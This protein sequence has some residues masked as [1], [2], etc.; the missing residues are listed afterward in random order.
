[1][2]VIEMLDVYVVLP[3]FDSTLI[4]SV[5]MEVF[6][7]DNKCLMVCVQCIPLTSLSLHSHTN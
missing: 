7:M 5:T 1:M 6:E 3:L 2:A 4:V